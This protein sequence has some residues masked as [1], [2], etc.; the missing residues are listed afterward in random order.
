MKSG[1][2][3]A[4]R[5][6]LA[7]AVAV[8][9]QIA[10]AAEG[11][12]QKVIEEIVVTAAGFQQNIA[13]APASITVIPRA[14]LETRHVRDLADA[15][16]AVEGVDVGAPLGKNGGRAISLRGMPAEYTLFLVDGRRQDAAGNVTPNG[17]GQTR[18]SFMPPP[19]AIERIE[20]VRGP[21]STLYG[22][23]AMGGVINIITRTPDENWGGEV[24]VD[25][26]LQNDD[27]FGDDRN[28]SVYLDGPVIPGKVALALRGRSYQRDESVYTFE[29]ANGNPVE[30]GG[31]AGGPAVTE[32]DTTSL[33]A[34]LT[35][36]PDDEQRIWFDADVNEQQYDNGQGQLGTLG[37]G[38]LPEL[39]F[40]REQYV[41]AYTAMVWDGFLDADLTHNTTETLGRT[42]PADVPGTG[43]RAGDARQIEATNDILNLKFYRSLGDHTFTVGGQ[44]WEAEMI[45]G[46][47]PK[48]FTHDQV[49]VFAEDEW[50]LLDPLALTLGARYDDHS[51]FG[52]N[53]SPRAYLIYDASDSITVK[54]GVSRGYKAPSL[55]QLADGIVGFGGQGTIPLL[56]SPDLGPETSTNYEMGLYYDNGAGFVANATVY[57]SDFEDKIASGPGVANCSYN[58]TEADYQAG[59]YS[60][61]GCT[62]VGWY[63]EG[64]G[65]PIVEFGQK[66]NVDKAET[67]GVELGMKLQL[68]EAISTS[69]SYTHSDSEQ[70]SGADEGEPLVELPKHRLTGSINWAAMDALNLRL[71]GEYNSSRYRGTGRSNDA[72]QEQ[73]GDY[74]AYSVFNLGGSYQFSDNLR[75]SATIYNLADKNFIE[76]RPFDY[77]GDT[78][79]SN[80]YAIAEEGRRLWVSLSLAF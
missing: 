79:Y 49:A 69:L 10:W 36:T 31:I 40:N 80:T 52:D 7:F 72:A 62:D 13:D 56:G 24:R 2:K 45:E 33:G 66:V 9:S 19:S 37:S 16:S 63:P 28:G 65:G 71:R 68:T 14:E 25:G 23:D 77:R 42:L 61:E 47:S 73:L 32:M 78:V 3:G 22:A 30:D 51:V 76:Y 46:L 39:E 27:R 18:S 44:Y 20:V 67:Q 50:R 74:E 75:L 6:S 8:A 70:K 60:T 57:R 35:W 58:V 34:R 48:V 29:D 21:M 54:G 1:A 5:G 26:T 59:N 4:S 64:R 41:L 53:W 43:R 55:D 12:S 17:F 11:E 15:L 38:Y